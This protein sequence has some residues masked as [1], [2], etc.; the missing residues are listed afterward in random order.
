VPSGTSGRTGPHGEQAPDRAHQPQT[1]FDDR[2]VSAGA[3][4][5]PG[6]P[7][8]AGPQARD[9]PSGTGGGPTEHRPGPGIQPQRPPD[10]PSDP[11]G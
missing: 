10:L 4:E 2:S 9:V 6:T 8:A 11:L 3:G 1:W 5:R 7:Q